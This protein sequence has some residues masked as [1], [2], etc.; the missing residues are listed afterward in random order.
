MRRTTLN[1]P[2]VD[3]PVYPSAKRAGVLVGRILLFLGLLGLIKRLNDEGGLQNKEDIDDGEARKEECR[4]QQ[5]RDVVVWLA[6]GSVQ[7]S[8]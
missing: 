3:P 5:R 6:K 7:L 4:S 1:R 2:K 8:W